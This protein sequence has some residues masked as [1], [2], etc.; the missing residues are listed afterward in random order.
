MGRDVGAELD[1]LVTTRLPHWLEANPEAAEEFWQFFKEGHLQ[2]RIPFAKVY[3][4]WREAWPEAPDSTSH[5]K[6]W[7]I[8]ELARRSR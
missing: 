4:K 3:A 1:E 7:A 5:T 6:R 2:R 8:G